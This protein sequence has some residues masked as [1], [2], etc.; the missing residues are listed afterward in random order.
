MTV[1]TESLDTLIKDIPFIPPNMLGAVFGGLNKNE[2]DKVYF[3][4]KLA[5]SDSK[6]ARAQLMYYLKYIEKNAPDLA[7]KVEEIAIA[8]HEEYNRTAG[9]DA[10]PYALSGFSES[11][12]ELL[13]SKI[14]HIQVTSGCSGR[15]DFCGFDALPGVRDRIPSKQ[16]ITLLD[17]LAERVD[18]RAHDFTAPDLYWASDPL[19][20]MENP[21]D[22]LNL[23]SQYETLFGTK[24]SF[25]TSI[26]PKT[27]LLYMELISLE[28][29]LAVSITPN[30]FKRLWTQGILTTNNFDEII[31]YSKTG[32][33]PAIL[34][35]EYATD[36]VRVRH[37]GN[38]SPLGINLTFDEVDEGLYGISMENVVLLTPYGVFNGV[39]QCG[40]DMEYP[41][42]FVMVSIGQISDKPMNLEF[43]HSI[44]E[45]LRDTVITPVFN[46]ERSPILPLSNLVENHTVGLMHPIDTI[47]I[48]D[49]NMPDY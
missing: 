39:N 30:N 19:E 27:E 5:E 7:K 29:P 15:C 48:I 32:T 21:K 35:E 45:Y 49:D 28:Y 4:E 8:A 33:E 2:E 18:K 22:F 24:L 13:L 26:P 41:Q 14:S 25:V 10:L 38:V 3:L 11:E 9:S 47:S 17:V 31:A 20:M 6:Q 37:P 40:A 1:D 36:D 12:V 16:L 23:L 42:A 44:S 46:A 34:E 43:G